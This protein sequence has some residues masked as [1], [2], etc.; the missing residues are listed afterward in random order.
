LNIVAASLAFGLT[1]AAPSLAIAPI[2]PLSGTVICATPVSQQ[3]A[4]VGAVPSPDEDTWI[5][6]NR[7]KLIFNEKI[8]SHAVTVTDSD[9]CKVSKSEEIAS[10]TQ[11]VV[12]MQACQRMGYPGGHMTVKYTVNGVAGEYHLHIRHHH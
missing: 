8:E 1:L 4:L 9:G 11:L 2:D 3:F 6:D 5:Q 12:H 10:G 7:I